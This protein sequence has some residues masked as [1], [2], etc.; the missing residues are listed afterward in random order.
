MSGHLDSE[1]QDA[2]GLEPL[3]KIAINFVSKDVLF[4]DAVREH[5]DTEPSILPI[6]RFDRL[7]EYQLDVKDKTDDQT[8]IVIICMTTSFEDSDLERVKQT[9]GQGLASSVACCFNAGCPNI[10]YKEQ[11]L[12]LGCSML[13]RSAIDMDE[14]M[15]A[16]RVMSHGH[17]FIQKEFYDMVYP[18]N[19]GHNS[20]VLAAGEHEVLVHLKRGLPN[21]QIAFELGISETAV[22]ARLRRLYRKLDVKSRTG[23]INAAQT[24][25]LI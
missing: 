11:L 19:S 8:C 4:V 13:H 1:P 6:R 25:G 14:F 18:R 5:L 20:R 9:L 7:S 16:V 3:Q 12:A 15:R 17:R 24:L 10:R 22:K 21:K 23:A 2:K